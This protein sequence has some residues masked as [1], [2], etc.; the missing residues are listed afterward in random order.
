MSEA[1]MSEAES[2]RAEAV[3]RSVLP[4]ASISPGGS[5]LPRR[6]SRRVR[7]AG[8]AAGA[9]LAATVTAVALLLAGVGGSAAAPRKPS[10]QRQPQQATT[11]GATVTVTGN[12]TATGT[13]DT[14]LLQIG[15]SARAASAAAALDRSSIQL[16]ALIKVLT[17]AGVAAKDIQTSML[18]LQPEYSSNGNTITGYEADDSVSVTLRDLATSGT[19]IDDA[20]HAVGNDVRIDGLDFYVANTAPLLARARAQAV[21]AAAGEAQQLA[22][23]AGTTLGP[24]VSITDESE[25]VPSPVGASGTISYAAGP[26][27]TP[28]PVQSGSQQVTAQVQ[29][30]YR[31]G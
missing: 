10:A 24:L 17:T 30:V 27:K 25:Q 16:N 15:V 23:A 12:G 7:P 11:G 1:P 19:V 5:L 20:A 22:T 8:V 6:P 9:G 14:V 21:Q 13:P 26:A 3:Q 28:V 31:L 29:V 4:E 18:D 2:D